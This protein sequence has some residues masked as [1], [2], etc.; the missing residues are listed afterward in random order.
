MVG[1]KYANIVDKKIKGRITKQN[2]L[3]K[4][5]IKEITGI[6]NRNMTCLNIER[7]LEYELFITELWAKR[8]VVWND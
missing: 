7:H 4:G 2:L 6:M 8:G 5:N 1:E 3:Q